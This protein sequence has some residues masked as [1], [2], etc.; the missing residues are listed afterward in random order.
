VSLGPLSLETSANN[1]ER[2]QVDE[3]QLDGVDL[4]EI[5]SATLR[6][7]G[8]GL[9][10][11]WR[12]D[13]MEVNHCCRS[14][15]T[16]RVVPVLFSYCICLTHRTIRSLLH[17]SQV[18]H[19]AARRTY[20]FAVHQWLDAKNGNVLEL[21]PGHNQGKR[22]HMY[23][24]LVRTSDLRGAGTGTSRSQRTPPPTACMV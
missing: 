12:V 3:F 11:A 4:G 24:V 20:S 18:K 22:Q 19:T 9:G 8:S 14:S 1:F 13:Q 10:A 15:L 17:Q 16:Y 2:G 5:T 7:D 23:K 21:A 6:Q